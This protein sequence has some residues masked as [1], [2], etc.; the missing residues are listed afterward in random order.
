M[1]CPVALWFLARALN[2]I[3]F[4]TPATVSME[5]TIRADRK[6]MGSCFAEAGRG[7]VVSYRTPDSASIVMKLDDV[8][9]SRIVAVANDKVEIRKGILYVND[10]CADDTMNLG[11]FF[12]V[13]TGAIPPGL[14]ALKEKVFPYS[15]TSSIVNASYNEMKKTGL[16]LKGK[17]IMD[18]QT[19]P[20]KQFK[21]GAGDRT[22]T[23]DNFGP[24]RVPEGFMFLMSDNRSNSVDSRVI[25]FIPRKNL[26]AKIFL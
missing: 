6:I 19:I 21:P 16:L 25:G 17:R 9:L 12:A 26:I 11:Y 14:L 8:F 1:T 2:W 7:D 23:E 20:A 15:D 5:P 13:N 10:K 3:V 4:Y 18:L 24:V 22:F